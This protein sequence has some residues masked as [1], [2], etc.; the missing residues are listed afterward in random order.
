MVGAA[1]TETAA[2]LDMIKFW[3]LLGS[4]IAKVANNRHLILRMDSKARTGRI[5]AGGL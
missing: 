2:S 4:S 5:K 1:P 3:G